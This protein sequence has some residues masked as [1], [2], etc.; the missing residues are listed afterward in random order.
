MS[1]SEAANR[2]P[3]VMVCTDYVRTG[4]QDVA[5]FALAD[6]LTRSGRDV[7]VVGHNFDPELAGRPLAH[8]HRVPKVANSI[9]V[10]APFLSGTGIAQYLAH[11]SERPI[12]IANGG[13]CPTPSAN[14]VHYVHAAYA[15]TSPLLKRRLLNAYAHPVSQLTEAIALRAARV[16]IANSDRTRNDVLAHFRLPEHRVKTIYY[17][18]DA[19]RFPLVNEEGKREALRA[20]GWVND[21]FRVAFVGAL[22]DRRKGFDTLFEAWRML[23]ARREWDGELVVVGQGV[24]LDVWRQRA[25]ENDLTDRIAF[26]GFRRDVPTILAACDA[27][28]APTR[29][30]AYGLGVHEALCTGLPAV[31]SADAGIAERYPAELEELLLDDFDDAANLAHVLR[32]VREKHA[33]LRA[34][35]ERFADELRSWSWDDMSADIER[36]CDERLS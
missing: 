30:E 21:R 14:W 33:T 31:V 29:Y 7:H 25:E 12:V 27:L 16:V 9:T 34:P 6:Y 19:S 8:L 17:G 22:G 3:F 10:S 20:L 23:C 4:G 36:T 32:S 13:N 11:R 26:L 1:D 35:I 5:N 15:P 28:A 24:E 18:T 2:R